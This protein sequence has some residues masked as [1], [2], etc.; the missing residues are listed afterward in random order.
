MVLLLFKCCSSPWLYKTA[1]SSQVT[2]L[3]LQRMTDLS[4]YKDHFTKPKSKIT[5]EHLLWLIRLMSELAQ[6]YRIPVP[7]EKTP[8]FFFMPQTSMC[9]ISA[10]HQ[11]RQACEHTPSVQWHWKIVARVVNWMKNMV[12]P[13]SCRNFI[14]ICY[15]LFSLEAL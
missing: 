6:T 3:S 1:C 10:T 8:L 15:H 13:H 5:L 7:S 11:V 9:L 4:R 2:W 14:G 12:I